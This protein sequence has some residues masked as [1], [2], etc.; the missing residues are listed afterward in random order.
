MPV[1]VVVMLEIV[2]VKNQKR[3]SSGF[4]LGMIYYLSAKLPDIPSVF[5][6]CQVVFGSKFLKLANPLGHACIFGN[7]CR[8]FG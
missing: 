2:D 6:A 4:F 3:H 8:L 5:Q 1:L 7:C